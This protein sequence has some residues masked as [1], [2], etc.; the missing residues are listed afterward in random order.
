MDELFDGKYYTGHA[1]VE[2]CDCIIYV[3]NEYD[4]YQNG[5]ITLVYKD[6]FINFSQRGQGNNYRCIMR[7]DQSEREVTDEE[8]EIL[9][10]MLIYFINSA[11]EQI[12]ILV[13]NRLTYTKLWEIVDKM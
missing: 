11:D 6:K 12:W 3:R 7:D 4:R 9:Y 2:H 1:Y 13:K 5:K 10:N 8:R